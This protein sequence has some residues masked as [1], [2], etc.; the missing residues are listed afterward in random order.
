L[1]DEEIADLLR[2]TFGSF[3]ELADDG[4]PPA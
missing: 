3:D 2:G 4:V 1:P